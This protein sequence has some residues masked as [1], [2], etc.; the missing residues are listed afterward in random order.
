MGANTFYTHEEGPTA[1][2]AFSAVV[3]QA[4]WEH[5]HSGYTGSIAEKHEFTL[6]ELPEGRTP[7][8][9]ADELI[10]TGDPRVDDKWGPA[11]CIKIPGK[12][13]W[14]FFGWASS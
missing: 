2:A 11:G 13:E 5:G 10:H 7:D 4:Q 1:K 8:E 3:S 14:L 12:D 9:Y 6:I